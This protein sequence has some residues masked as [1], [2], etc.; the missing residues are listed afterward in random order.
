MDVSPLESIVEDLKTLPPGKLGV[1]AG[2]VHRL[3]RISEKERQTV[4]AQTFG[5]LSAEDAEAM[6]KA[7]GR[8][9]E[10]MVVGEETDRQWTKN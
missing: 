9:C 8:G 6:A 2:F 5:S 10:R 1:A 7:I 4:L 3:S